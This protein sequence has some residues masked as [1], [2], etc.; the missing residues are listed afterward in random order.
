MTELDGQRSR[1]SLHGSLRFE[2]STQDSRWQN[3]AMRSIQKPNTRW[4]H[5][6]A[7][8][9]VDVIACQ[10]MSS[11]S[12]S[13]SISTA[14]SSS[15]SSSPSSSSESPRSC[16][17]ECSLHWHNSTCSHHCR[18]EGRTGLRLCFPGR[19]GDYVGRT[20]SDPQESRACRS[21]PKQARCHGTSRRELARN[22]PR[23]CRR[24]L[25][26]SPRPATR[27][28]PPMPAVRH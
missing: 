1:L 26:R 2:D 8:V 27:A 12:S 16:T 21:K 24:H 15:S 14:E 9:S 18:C 20:D 22:S 23:A 25:G 10:S 11:P 3:R 13:V 28:Y 19:T 17:G 4:W 6:D 5:D 7:P